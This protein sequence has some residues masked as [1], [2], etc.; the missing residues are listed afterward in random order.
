VAIPDEY[1]RIC[2]VMPSSAPKQKR[3]NKHDR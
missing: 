1:G 3:E 2:T